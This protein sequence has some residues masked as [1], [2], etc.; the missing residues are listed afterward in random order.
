MHKVE[1][2]F[3]SLVKVVEEFNAKCLY[4]KNRNLKHYIFSD[5]EAKKNCANSS[6]NDEKNQFYKALSDFIKKINGL[7]Q[8]FLEY[9]NSSDV[10]KA[11]EKMKNGDISCSEEKTRAIKKTHGLPPN[12]T[13]VV[14]VT[15]KKGSTKSEKAELAK[16]HKKTKEANL[17]LNVECKKTTKG[18]TSKSANG[19]LKK[20]M[21]LRNRKKIKGRNVEKTNDAEGE[22]EIEKETCNG[23]SAG[24]ENRSNDANR[25]ADI[26]VLGEES[27]NIICNRNFSCDDEKDSRGST[28]RSMDILQ[29]DNENSVSELEDEHIKKQR[30]SVLRK[31][32]IDLEYGINVIRMSREQLLEEIKEFY[33]VHNREIKLD[34]Y[35]TFLNKNILKELKEKVE[36]DSVNFIEKHTYSFKDRKSFFIVPSNHFFI[37]NYDDNNDEVCLYA[38]NRTIYETGT[39]EAS[40]AG[41]HIYG[42]NSPA[43]E[44]VAN[45]GNNTILTRSNSNSHAKLNSPNFGTEDQEEG[46]TE[47]ENEMEAVTENESKKENTDDELY[48]KNEKHGNSKGNEFPYSGERQQSPNFGSLEVDSSHEE[49]INDYDVGGMGSYGSENAIQ[50]Q[51]DAYTYTTDSLF[52]TSMEFSSNN[53]PLVNKKTKNEYNY[54]VSPKGTQSSSAVNMNKLRNCNKY[55]SEMMI[56]NQFLVS[57]DELANSFCENVDMHR[58]E[59]MRVTHANSSMGFG[60][61]EKDSNIDINANIFESNESFQNVENYEMIIKNEIFQNRTNNNLNSNPSDFFKRICDFYKMKESS[62]ST[63][64]FV[65]ENIS[66]YTKEMYNDLINVTGNVTGSKDFAD[67]SQENTP[68]TPDMRQQDTNNNTVNLCFDD[69]LARAQKSG[70]NDEEK[71]FCSGMNEGGIRM[72]RSSTSHSMEF[73]EEE[74]EEAGITQ[75][76]Q[77]LE[78]SYEKDEQKWLVHYCK[79]DYNLYRSKQLKKKKESILEYISKW[80]NKIQNNKIEEMDKSETKYIESGEMLITNRSTAN[81]DHMSYFDVGD[82]NYFN[83]VYNTMNLKVIYEVNRSACEYLEEV[84]FFVGQVFVNKYKIQKIISKTKF[85]TTLKCLNLHYKKGMPSNGISNNSAKKK[86]KRKD[87]KYLCLKVMKCGKSYFDQGVFELI[88]LNV[89][90]ESKMEYCANENSNSSFSR[91]TNTFSNEEKDIYA[92]GSKHIIELYDYFY[93]KEQL[94]IV[95]EYMQSDLYDYFIK[96]GKMGTLGQ[97][98]ILAKSLLEG[99]AFI[100]SNQLIH[101]DLKPENVMVTMKRRKSR[102]RSKSFTERDNKD[103]TFQADEKKMCSFSNTYSNDYMLN[104]TNIQQHKGGIEYDLGNKREGGNGSKTCI[105]STSSNQIKAQLCNVPSSMGTKDSYDFDAS[106]EQQRKNTYKKSYEQTL[107]EKENLNVCSS[108]HMNSSFSAV[109]AVSFDT[110]CSNTVNNNNSTSN[111]NSSSSFYDSSVNRRRQSTVFNDEEFDKIKII[112][113]NSAIYE[114]D[115]LEMYVQTRCYR[116]P[117]VLLQENYD[118]KIDIWSLGCILFEFITTKILFDYENLYRFIYS[119]ATYIGSFPFY[120]INC[121]KIPYMFTKHGLIVLDKVVYNKTGNRFY[122]DKE[123]NE[124]DDDVIFNSQDFFRLNERNSTKESVYKK[125]NVLANSLTEKDS[126]KEVYYDV[127]YPSDN[128]LRTHFHINDVMFLDFLLSLLQ[129]DPV[130]RPDAITALRHPWLQRGLYDDGL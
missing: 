60:N 89:L 28:D 11:S 53:E 118:R 125:R 78:N 32:V 84:N 76:E 46:I 34:K 25:N 117:E 61:R 63:D 20:T 57:G 48:K 24:A 21:K 31:Y 91:S 59:T 49:I 56:S 62:I 90:N 93:Y 54:S 112:D 100:H 29:S 71:I 6:G 82:D 7:H 104:E 99:I 51:R 120:M 55:A 33:I 127:C 114:S 88:V 126:N 87:Y 106:V 23:L 116:S 128:R 38:S 47:T 40:K 73:I 27:N 50:S 1:E 79:G 72:V 80:E 94:V 36:R 14:N 42:Y 92:R 8:N 45:F 30:N 81:I 3:F 66:R 129:I 124:S 18:L 101:C 107:N 5:K 39:N 95:T 119:I 58:G 113:F 121:C 111:I 13:A 12:K 17:N 115:K 37:R 105:S 110:C 75:Q 130:K 77:K 123:I 15:E 52:N 108:G 4:Y 103:E 97:L 98:Q 2:N 85:S 44:G 74:I 68:T 19:D 69:G 83:N 10:K 102:R 109:S 67:D 26:D 16:A 35:V 65:D 64:T 41:G 86:Q 9:E 122:R 22:I 96:K 43:L 70:E